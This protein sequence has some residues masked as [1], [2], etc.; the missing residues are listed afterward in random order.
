MDESTEELEQPS[1]LPQGAEMDFDVED[2]NGDQVVV[3]EQDVSYFSS[4]N[5]R[6]NSCVVTIQTIAPKDM[7]DPHYE[8]QDV[9]PEHNSDN[10]S[11]FPTTNLEYGLQ[12][13]LLSFTFR[14]FKL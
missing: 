11:V 12:V 14:M 1:V 6:N 9:F 5:L 10:V 7:Q 4:I 13:N 8:A 2:Q 3:A